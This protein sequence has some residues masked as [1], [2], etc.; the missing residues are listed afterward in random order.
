MIPL[1]FCSYMLFVSVND[2]IHSPSVEK[3]QYICIIN[4]NNIISI[5][6]NHPIYQQLRHQNFHPVVITIIS[7]L[8]PLLRLRLYHCHSYR[9]YYSCVLPPFLPSIRYA[10]QDIDLKVSSSSSSSSS[11]S[12]GRGSLVC[13]M[14]SDN[15]CC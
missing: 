12:K 10:P 5:I 13:G 6:L 15:D 7:S 11:S 8:H 9:Y 3:L 14:E 4:P 2:T 1:F